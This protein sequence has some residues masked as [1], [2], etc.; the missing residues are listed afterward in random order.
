MDSVCSGPFGRSSKDNYVFGQSGAGSSWAKGHYKEHVELVDS[1]LHA[2]RKKAE[3]CDYLQNLQLIHCR[4]ST[5][6]GS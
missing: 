4:R 1:E 5:Q 6:T 2:V 3:N